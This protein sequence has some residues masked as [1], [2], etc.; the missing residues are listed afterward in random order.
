[1]ENNIEPNNTDTDIFYALTRILDNLT[2]VA[3]LFIGLTAFAYIIGWLEYRA[4]FNE[5]GASWIM[6]DLQPISIL[7]NSWIPVALFVFFAYLT[8][9]DLAEDRNFSKQIFFIL[10]YYKWVL[11]ILFI[12]QFILEFL[13]WRLVFSIFSIFFGLYTILVAT[14]AYGYLLIIFADPKSKLDLPTI[15]LIYTL[16]VFGFYFSPTNMGISRAYRDIDVKLNNLPL[17]HCKSSDI[18]ELR[19]IHSNQ[20]RYYAINLPYES[21]YPITYIL[22]RNDIIYIVKKTIKDEQ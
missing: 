19:L 11:P 13:K 3:S 8:T 14:A 6:N 17:V 21:E 20:D 7:S 2:K 9:V 18:P 10:K 16:L 12:I 22:N 1:M 15:S 5:F 4:Y